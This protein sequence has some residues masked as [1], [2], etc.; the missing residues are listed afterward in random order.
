MFDFTFSGFSD[1]TKAALNGVPFLAGVVKELPT[2]YYTK[3][4]QAVITFMV[5]GLIGWSASVVMVNKATGT[6]VLSQLK[7]LNQQLVYMQESII[8]N[9]AEIKT[10][11]D[12]TRERVFRPEWERK[13]REQ[14]ARLLHLERTIK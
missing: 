12:A 3:L 14:D 7:L 11:K 9:K 6:Q 1:T 10:L 2:P 5:I 8:E 13:A 4:L